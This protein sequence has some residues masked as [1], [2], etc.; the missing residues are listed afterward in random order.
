LSIGILFTQVADALSTKLGLQIGATEANGGMAKLIT[1][2][3]IYNF[4]IFKLVA[5]LFLIWAFWKRPTAAAFII[6]MYVAVVLNNLIVMLQ[7]V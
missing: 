1:E 4:I 2:Y 5:S 7:L 3:G 6:C